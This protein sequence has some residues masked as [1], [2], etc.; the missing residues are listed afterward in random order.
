MKNRRMEAESAKIRTKMTT[1]AQEYSGEFQAKINRGS[2]SFYLF[3][4]IKA[5]LFASFSLNC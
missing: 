5:G 3:R 2:T 1:I 4:K